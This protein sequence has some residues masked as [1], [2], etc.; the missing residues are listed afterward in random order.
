MTGKSSLKSC[1]CSCTSEPSRFDFNASTPAHKTSARPVSCTID[2]SASTS[3]KPTG[4]EGTWMEGRTNREVAPSS[5]TTCTVTFTSPL[6][7]TIS[8]SLLLTAHE[9]YCRLRA[10]SSAAFNGS[11]SAGSSRRLQ[12]P[13]GGCG[14]TLSLHHEA[15]SAVGVVTETTPLSLNEPSWTPGTTSSAPFRSME[16]DRG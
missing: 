6:G 15:G 8:C 16:L 7:S 12:D 4:R 2:F 13:P 11:L 10:E 1:C 14:T 5:S 9:K 3:S